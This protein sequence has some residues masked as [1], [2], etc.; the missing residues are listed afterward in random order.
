MD[1]PYKHVTIPLEQLGGPPPEGT[2][3]VRFEGP[4]LSRYEANFTL[5]DPQ[6]DRLSAMLARAYDAGKHAKAAEVRNVLG[7]KGMVER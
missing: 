5:T 3:V 2:S 6:R 1:N 4:G 7:A